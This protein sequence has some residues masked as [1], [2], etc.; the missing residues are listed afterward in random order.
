MAGIEIHLPRRWLLPQHDDVRLPTSHPCPILTTSLLSPYFNVPL[1]TASNNTSPTI[2]YYSIAIV[3]AGSFLGRAMSGFLA[4]AFGVWHVFSI[5]G[6]SL[7]I[8]LLAF[9][10]GVPLPGAVVVIGIL[11][12]GF[13]SGAWLALV[14]ASCATIGP[15][16]EFGMRLGMLWSCTAV[17]QTFGPVIA[18]GESILVDMW[19]RAD[20]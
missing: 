14:A 1:Y 9:W 4:D 18:G 16:R 7:T 11:T 8:T 3:Q 6:F 15:T 20:K 5:S 2:T 10:T 19:D 12:Y 17:L 13:A